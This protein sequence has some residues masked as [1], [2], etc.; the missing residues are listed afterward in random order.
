MPAPPALDQLPASWLAALCACAPP[1]DR[2]A[3]R[4]CCRSLLAAADG[5]GLRLSLADGLGSPRACAALALSGAQLAQLDLTGVADV[6][7]PAA[8]LALPRLACLCCSL[9]QQPL[10]AAVAAGS[11]HLT[12][13]RACGA[14]LADA[15]R[16]AAVGSEL[17]GLV[18]SLRRLELDRAAHLLL[19]HE[20]CLW[21]AV[22]ALTGLRELCLAHERPRGHAPR[23][24]LGRQAWA[25]AVAPLAELTRLEMGARGA[26]GGGG[27]GGGGGGAGPAAPPPPPLPPLAALSACGFD[28]ELAAEPSWALAWVADFG[29]T[30]T[31]LTLTACSGNE[32]DWEALGT[33]TALAE[34]SLSVFPDECVE[35]SALAPLAACTGLTSLRLLGG[36]LVVEPG[37]APPGGAAAAPPP[38]RPPGGAGGAQGQRGAARLPQL[39]GLRKV[40]AGLL[41]KAPVA[42]LAPNLTAL[43]DLDYD[44]AALELGQG[45]VDER[46]PPGREPLA[47]LAR[48]SL[49]GANIHALV[50]HAATPALHGAPLAELHLD[51]VGTL[52]G[53]LAG[54]R[55]LPRLP[56]LTKL[57]M[58][59]RQQACGANLAQTYDTREDGALWRDQG[60]LRV[61]R[62]RGSRLLGGFLAHDDLLAELPAALPRLARLE[63]ARMADLTAE[64][65]GKLAAAGAARRI[66][67]QGCRGVSARDCARV[68]AAAG[69]GAAHVAVEFLG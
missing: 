39:V 68:E 5:A 30:L 17:P 2:L 34:L 6:A 54:G 49:L 22:G 37:H 51:M 28:D 25:A 60:A 29:A 15:P 10:L 44:L 40:V 46:P 33:L 45:F 16:W 24:A 8:A 21:A 52:D 62:L 11:P 32:V 55:A 42:E 57:V 19:T 56:H 3:L 9:A 66:T 38:R 50:R 36:A 61:L 53:A 63:L 26:A 4:C 41:C 64:D 12:A 20:P 1:H 65:L 67:V 14:T 43:R 7:P 23:C 59:L 13:L 58:S 31:S 69:G 27:G 48:L 35:S 18:A 47:G